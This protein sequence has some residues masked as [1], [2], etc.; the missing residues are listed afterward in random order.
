LQQNCEIRREEGGATRY[1]GA[2]SAA[3]EFDNDQWSVRC[4]GFVEDAP[5]RL[6]LTV[7]LGA[8]EGICDV[9]VEEHSDRVELEVLV[10]PELAP[11]GVTTTEVYLR[12]ALSGRRLVDLATGA[13]IPAGA[14]P[15]QSG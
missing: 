14:D 6:R 3:P 10:C 4:R 12:T 7:E 9:F 11:G 13:L 5:G 1:S 8:G 2:M 15:R